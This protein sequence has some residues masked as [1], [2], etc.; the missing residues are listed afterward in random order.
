[1]TSDSPAVQSCAPGE[2]H[3][4]ADARGHHAYG[5]LRI[6][7]PEERE[8]NEKAQ[9]SAGGELRRDD[10]QGGHLIGTL[11]G[12]APDGVNLVPQNKNVNQKNYRALEREWK[13][14]LE[15]GCQ[16]FVDVYGTSAEKGRT[17]AVYGSYTVIKPDGTKYTEGFSYTNESNA[18]Q[19]QWEKEIEE[20][21]L[22]AH[23]A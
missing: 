22:L 6:C 16:V 17:D 12:G 20:M 23:K 1:M 4:S 10:D 21:D 14:L 11:F 15:S 9:R 2:Y 8:R 19:E 13:T 7:P 3:Y 18:T 5:Q